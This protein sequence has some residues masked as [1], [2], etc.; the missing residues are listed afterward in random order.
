MVTPIN[1]GLRLHEA[2][3]WGSH[4]TLK[5]VVNETTGMKVSH[6][7]TSDTHVTSQ[8]FCSL[9]LTSPKSV[10]AHALV[11]FSTMELDF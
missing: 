3:L 5:V 11:K 10:W 2:M 9:D 7:P 1:G 4:L 6:Q 8:D